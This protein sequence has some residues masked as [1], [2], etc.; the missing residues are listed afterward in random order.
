MSELKT[1]PQPVEVLSPVTK[2]EKQKARLKN[3]MHFPNGD[4]D[5]EHPHMQGNVY[6][7]P[8]LPDGMWCWTSRLLWVDFTIGI[9]ETKNTIYILEGPPA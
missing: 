1:P 4:G 6:D 7:H 3:W 2:E 9:C 8:H 5:I